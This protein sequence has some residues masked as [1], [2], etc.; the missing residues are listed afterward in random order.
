MVD[1]I[2]ASSNFLA[3][4][5]M[6]RWGAIIENMRSFSDGSP[7]RSLNDERGL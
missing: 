1:P 4:E 7:R 6:V 3:F 2:G 5:E